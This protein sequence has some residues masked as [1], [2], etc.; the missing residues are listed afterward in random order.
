MDWLPQAQCMG[1]AAQ[2]EALPHKL[3]PAASSVVV[4]GL[5]K[6]PADEI[7]DPLRAQKKVT[8]SFSAELSQ[9]SMAAGMAAAPYC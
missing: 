2:P 3:A 8:R 5:Y 4:G 7:V 1:D 6:L 9:R